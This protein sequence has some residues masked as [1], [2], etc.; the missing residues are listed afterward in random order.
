MDNSEKIG[1][2]LANRLTTDI[3]INND[4]IEKAIRHLVE[5]IEV[6]NDYDSRGD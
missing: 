4:D 5:N 2:E 1:C 3:P 6:M